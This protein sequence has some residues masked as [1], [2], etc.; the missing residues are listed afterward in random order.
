[1]CGGPGV[2]RR[3]D[4]PAATTRWTGRRTGGARPRCRRCS[5]AVRR[6]PPRPVRRAHR[7]VYLL[8][9]ETPRQVTERLQR[10]R[11]LRR[12]GRS[13]VRFGNPAAR[14]RP[15]HRGRGLAGGRTPARGMEPAAIAAAQRRF[16]ASESVG[17]RR[18]AALSGGRQGG[19]PRTPDV[20]SLEVAPNLW[21]GINGWFHP[22]AGTALVSPRNSCRPP[23]RRSTHGQKNR[24]RP[25]HPVRLSAPGGGVPVRRRR[26]SGT[27]A[28]RAARERTRRPRPAAGDRLT[29]RR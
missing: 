18:M 11:A 8:W 9:G 25:L 5:S 14:H 28:A 7:R 27:A 3:L 20:R 26:P 2:G 15:A 23:F 17:Q 1:M 12:R 29:A 19:E 22:V 10:M 6:P 16:A 13:D 24:R 21:A 4:S